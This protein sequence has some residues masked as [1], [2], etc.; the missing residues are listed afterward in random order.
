MIRIGANQKPP[1]C[2]AK[3]FAAA[4]MVAGMVSIDGN[5]PDACGM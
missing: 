1:T 4:L 2:A 3:T 5:L